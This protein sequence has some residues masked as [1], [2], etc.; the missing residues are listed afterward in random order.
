MKN[1]LAGAAAGVAATIPMT[2]VMETLHE[3]LT[4]EV[5]RPLPPR[6]IAEGLA[7]KFGVRRDLSELDMQNLTLALHVG[8]A[9][10][11]GAILSTMAPSKVGAGAAVGALFGLGVWATSYLGWLPVSGV[12]QPVTY[13][14]VARTGLMVAAHLAWGATAGVIL[15]AMASRT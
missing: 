5:P 11:T 12:R 13:D 8:Y 4:G 3:R 15:A 6:E 1:V 2:M 7:V 9:A 10:M 14:P